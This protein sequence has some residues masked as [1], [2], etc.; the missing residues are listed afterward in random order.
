[1][2]L[3]RIV[4]ALSCNTKSAASVSRMA[5]TPSAVHGWSSPDASG[6]SRVLATWRSNGA[7][8]QIIEHDACTSHEE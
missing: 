7:I 2:G 1:M 5:R 8:G 3:N 4:R 6:R